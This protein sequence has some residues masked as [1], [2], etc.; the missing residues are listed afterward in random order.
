V[1]KEH[2]IL[3]EVARGAMDWIDLA[4]DMDK[5]QAFVNAGDELSGSIKCWEFNDHL[6]TYY[7][8]RKDSAPWR[9]F[10]PHR[11]HTTSALQ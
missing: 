10:L 5:L 7:V 4:Q 6:R 11:Q 3:Q 8:L 1:E 2:E 9:Y